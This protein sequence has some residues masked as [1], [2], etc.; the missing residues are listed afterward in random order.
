MHKEHLATYRT[1][2]EAPVEKVWE[3]L[4][5]PALVKQ[6]FFGS[7]L[8]TDWK[9]NSPI[10]WTGEF[11]GTTYLDKG[12]VLEFVPNEKLSFSYLS[13]W[14]GMEDKPENYL[15]VSYAVK[16]SGSG[17]ELT[18]TQSNYDAERAKHSADNWAMVMEG[19]KKIVE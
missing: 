1:T 18:I 14:S 8:K 12:V 16:P 5:D 11:E 15:W 19:M 9:V 17:T 10:Q 4:T 6:Y 3:A 2:V 7:D 13:S